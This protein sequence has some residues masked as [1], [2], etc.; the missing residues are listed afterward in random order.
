MNVKQ[1]LADIPNLEVELEM[2]LSKKSTMRLK[3]FGDLIVAKSEEALCQTLDILTK[4]NIN[5]RLLGWG[6]NQLLPECS[7]VPY[8]KLEFPFDKSYL[9]Q[10]RDLYELPAS[11][12]L[13]VLSSHAVKHGLKGWEVFTGVP[14]SLGGAIFMN[15]GTNLGEIGPLVKTVK[16]ATKTGEK[17][18]IHI[19]ENSF[20][21]RKNHFVDDGDVIY[22]VEMVHLGIDSAISE[23]I[24]KYL[25][26]RN[27]T[28]PLKEFT[29]GCV[30]KNSHVIRNR[31]SL[32]CRAGLYI[33][34]MGLKGFTCGDIR[35]SPLHANFMENSGDADYSDVVNAINLIKDELK[36]QFGVDFDTEVRI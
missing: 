22:A 34:I 29:C 2:D 31:E 16:V 12:S 30:F 10:P 36:L 4:N 13:S 28:Q 7:K 15:A 35:V 14:A 8:L 24:K 3:A 26:L 1:L 18:V 21:Y 9:D 27:K 17:K 20:S 25:D 32:T 33:D 11:A 23:K 19:D 6:A 5:Y